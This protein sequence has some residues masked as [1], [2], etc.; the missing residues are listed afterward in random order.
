MEKKPTNEHHVAASH[1]LGEMRIKMAEIRELFD[2]LPEPYQNALKNSLSMSISTLRN[3]LFELHT[4]VR[5]EGTKS[6]QKPTA[7]K[8]DPVE[9]EIIERMHKLFL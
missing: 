6:M 5:R 4:I 1:L 8:F 3:E 7:G 9:A 2:A